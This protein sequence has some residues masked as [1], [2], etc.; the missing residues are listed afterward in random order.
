MTLIEVLI[1]AIVV[2]IGLLGVAS[3]QISALQGSV[4]A[5][6]RSRAIDLA[7]SLSDRM[8]A[9][10]IAVA[11]NHYL[12]S[13]DCE[14]GPE[15]AVANC[16]MTPLTA[17]SS[18]VR[19][20]TPKQMADFDLYQISCGPGGIQESLPNGRLQVTCLDADTSDA[21]RCSELSRLL[22]RISWQRQANVTDIEPD[23]VDGIIM[24]IVI[25]AP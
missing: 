8:Q 2:A 21:D 16:S 5:D 17:S 12:A 15:T 19:Q 25:G 20:C 6:Y 18:S 24:T 13:P 4:N 11:D 7:T 22:I 9:N 23:E 1:A 3:L 10:L 14:T